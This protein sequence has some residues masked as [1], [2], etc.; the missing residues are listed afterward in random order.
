MQKLCY[1]GCQVSR[2]P[3]DITDDSGGAATDAPILGPESGLQVIQ[4]SIT[5]GTQRV[6]NNMFTGTDGR[7]D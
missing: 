7:L 4:S 6:V 2:F 5:Q 1:L 3:A